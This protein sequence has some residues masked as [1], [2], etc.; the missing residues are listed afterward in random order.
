[1]NQFQ[2]DCYLSPELKP[3]AKKV[4]KSPV[5]IEYEENIYDNTHINILFKIN[6]DS[7][8]EEEREEIQTIIVELSSIQSENILPMISLDLYEDVDDV[9]KFKVECLF[10]YPRTIRQ[11]YENNVVL[12]DELKSNIH[13]IV[14]IYKIVVSQKL[15]VELTFSTVSFAS[16]RNQKL[17][18][19]QICITPYAFING[20]LQRKKNEN[21]SYYKSFEMIFRELN[22]KV[23]EIT[24]K[25]ELND[26]IDVLKEDKDALKIINNNKFIK[27]VK[28]FMKI[29]S[30]DIDSFKF[31]SNLG[32][33][34]FGN[35]YKV[36]NKKT[37][38]IY[39]LKQAKEDENN[40]NANTLHKEA[41]VLDKLK[42][43]NIVQCHGFA[44]SM[45]D[46]VYDTYELYSSYYMLIEFCDKGDLLSYICN[47]YLENENSFEDN[48]DEPQQRRI[49]V[50]T[51][52]NIIGQMMA[53]C[54][55]L[56]DKR[57]VHRDW[58]LENILINK[59][60]P[61]FWIKISDF[62]FSRTDDI[63]L[64]SIAGSPYTA[65]PNILYNEYYTDRS[66]LFSIGCIFYSLVYL[67]YPCDDCENYDD[68]Y[69]KVTN[70]EITYPEFPGS[71][72]YKHIIELTQKLLNVDRRTIDSVV[73]NAEKVWNE[74][75]SNE[76]IVY[77]M[78]K[79]AS[80][81]EKYYPDGKYDE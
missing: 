38:K 60:E 48:D 58:K 51:I 50:E 76:F 56:H 63:L 42:H 61:F 30:F 72:N 10:T 57:I 37:K 25:E 62:G 18:F 44:E 24:G 16:F 23:F 66:E 36:I 43:P 78:K 54:F 5:T 12:E 67:K 55:Y 20:F 11:Y 7:L 32:D 41:F 74:F 71:E 21:I 77:C 52:E 8:T 80:L 34:T 59:F 13:D 64:K 68:I 31:V 2:F 79:V 69:D 53:G 29:K 45:K 28:Q 19:P 4:E 47:N 75:K 81:F 15:P 49:P 73:I 40:E 9:N 14:E 39:A 70:D 1:M 3:L 35:V 27:E 26:I 6:F 65:D 22:K 33:G 46:I 17:P